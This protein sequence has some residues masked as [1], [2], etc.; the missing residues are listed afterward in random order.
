MSVAL[1]VTPK[2]GQI[3]RLMLPLSEMPYSVSKYQI[4]IINAAP[5]VL[6]WYLKRWYKFNMVSKMLQL[7][8]T[9]D[10]V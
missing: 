10:D 6:Q 1:K 8:K 9:Q 7:Y 3:Q 5:I 2:P 4:E